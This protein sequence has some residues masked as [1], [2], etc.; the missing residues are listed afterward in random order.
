MG[1]K[2]DLWKSCTKYLIILFI[3]LFFLCWWLCSL[4]TP[5]THNVMMNNTGYIITITFALF[6]IYERYLW[7]KLNFF[8]I[9]VMNSEY[10]GIIEYNFK[11]K[12]NFKEIELSVKQTLFTTNIKIK[13]DEI[14]SNSITSKIVLENNEHI[15]YY[16]YITNPKMKNSENNPIQYGA[17]RLPLSNVEEIE[18]IYWTTRETRGDI[19]LKKKS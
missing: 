13:T 14:V 4:F 8:K 9:P 5:V 16:T 7:K 6:W 10:T 11:N 1:L 19:K 15:L 2:M 18:G 17:C 3:I 12:E